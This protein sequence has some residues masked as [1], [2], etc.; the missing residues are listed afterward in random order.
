VARLTRPA[1]D[2]QQ[3]DNKPTWPQLIDKWLHN[4]L[5]LL[6]LL[7]A[8]LALLTTLVLITGLTSASLAGILTAALYPTAKKARTRISAA[9]TTNNPSEP[10][11]NEPPKTTNDNNEQPPDTPP[12][13][14]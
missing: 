2:Q 5:I 10:T 3:G 13:Q 14:P 12:D 9:H 1:A 8:F 4:P 11:Q 6:T 7:T